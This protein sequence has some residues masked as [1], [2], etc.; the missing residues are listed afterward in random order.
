MRAQYTIK[1]IILKNFI[2]HRETIIDF[3]QGVT[4]LIGPNGAGK[5]SILEAIYFALTGKGWRA[6]RRKKDLI[7]TSAR[8]ATVEMI[9]SIGDNEEL[10]IKRKIPGTPTDTIL[11]LRVD[12]KTVDTARG[13]AQV[14]EKIRE[15]LGLDPEKLRT[16]AIIPQGGITR[17]FTDL[18]PFERKK[19]IDVLLGIDDYEKAY[20]NIVKLDLKAPKPLASMGIITVTPHQEMIQN[21][22]R[23]LVETMPRETRETKQQLDRLAREKSNAEKEIK[24]I[25]EEIRKINEEIEKLEKEVKELEET[26]IKYEKLETIIERLSRE[27]GELGNRIKEYEEKIRA[28]EEKLVHMKRVEKILEMEKEYSEYRHKRK[29]L[30]ELIERNKEI[31]EEIKRLEPIKKRLEQLISRI[32]KPLE[33]LEKEAEERQNTIKEKQEQLEKLAGELEALKHEE[34]GLA[35]ELE[36]LES[37]I[38]DFLRK[39]INLLEIKVTD[40]RRVPDIVLEKTMKLIEEHDRLNEELKTI[41]KKIGELEALKKQEMEKLEILRGTGEGKCPLCGQPLT[42][43]HRA[44]I[45]KKTREKIKRIG[46][47]LDELVNTKKKLENRLKTLENLIDQAR[48]LAALAERVKSFLEKRDVLEPKLKDLRR[49]IDEKTRIRE[50]IEKEIKDLEASLEEINN[51]INDAK[52]YNDLVKLSP[53]KKLD[54]LKEEKKRIGD[55]ITML[56]QWINSFEDKMKKLIEGRSA[57][58]EEVFAEARAK[59]DKLVMLAGQKEELEKALDK[60]REEKKTKK[61]ELEKL[62]SE[63][64]KLKSKIEELEKAKKRKEEL[65]EKKEELLR[66]EAELRA[67]IESLNERIEELGEKLEELRSRERAVREILYK[68]KIL[69]WIRDNILHRDKAPALLRRRY[70]RLIEALMRDYIR[71]FEL[72]Y[73]DVSIDDDFNIYLKAPGSR[74]PIEIARLSG[75]EKVAVSLVA[76]LALHKVVGSDRLGFLILDEPTEFLDDERRRKLIELLKKFGGGKIIKQLIIVTHDEEIKEAAET[77]YRVAKTSGYSRVERVEIG[78]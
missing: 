13:E 28:I 54:V 43:E 18:K 73:N 72:G 32:K 64:E 7:N 46:S 67:R 27:I 22:E 69:Q 35:K 2:S 39:T 6:Q 78:G 12:G 24:R 50:E 9:M 77:L 15:I 58:Y 70:T 44:E 62:A 29:R 47:E 49:T 57:D 74:I 8:E 40:P 34:A 59:Y 33:Q 16:I 11:Q 65:E 61:K 31:E 4:V 60:I 52:L 53:P 41:E 51:M 37:E 21:L 25:E 48:N 56:N 36:N 66:R 76:M 3:D 10:Y 17:L 71:V 30:E 5:T 45:I 63:L 38:K 75:G 1:K 55:E 26:R 68:L 20:Q 19:I 23:Y 14:N 42:E